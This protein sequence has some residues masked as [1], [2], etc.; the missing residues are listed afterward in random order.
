MRLKS[1]KKKKNF[2]AGRKKWCSY[3]KEGISSVEL[4]VVNRRTIMRVPWSLWS[5]NFFIQFRFIL[6]SKRKLKLKAYIVNYHVLI[7]PGYI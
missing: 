2:Q 6:Y 1:L 3:E 7:L 5:V 4:C